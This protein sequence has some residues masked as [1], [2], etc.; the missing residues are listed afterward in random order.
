MFGWSNLRQ[1]TR[2]P[3]LTSSLWTQVHLYLLSTEFSLLCESKHTCGSTLC[4]EHHWYWQQCRAIYMELHLLTRQYLHQ[5]DTNAVFSRWAAKQNLCSLS[6][7]FYITMTTI[8]FMELMNGL[9]GAIQCQRFTH[10]HLPVLGHWLP[11]PQNLPAHDSIF[12]SC[13]RQ[14]VGWHDMD[15][16]GDIGIQSGTRQV[17][18][19]VGFNPMRLRH[20]HERGVLLREVLTGSCWNQHICVFRTVW[21]RGVWQTSSQLRK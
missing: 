13:A 5:H 2:L 12:R 17:L 8:N 6:G 19:I 9:L 4:R 16:D 7:N 3:T 18:P 10:I 15:T 14:D 20:L 11:S 1:A 21:D